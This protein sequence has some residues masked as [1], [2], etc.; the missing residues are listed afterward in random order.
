[1]NL[2]E[3]L[4]D[5]RKT[6]AARVLAGLTQA[7]LARALGMSFQ[8]LQKYETGANALRAAKLVELADL[9]WGRHELSL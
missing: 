6:R 5:R 4:D 3:E 1:M 2:E 7:E 8:Q 9:P